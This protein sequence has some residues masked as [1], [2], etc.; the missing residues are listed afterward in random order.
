MSY[1]TGS[2]D[3]ADFRSHRSDKDNGGNAIFSAWVVASISYHT[4]KMAVNQDNRQ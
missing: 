2:V 4:C 3:R 1:V